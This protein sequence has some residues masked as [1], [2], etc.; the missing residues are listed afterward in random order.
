MVK[1][2]NQSMS[3]TSQGH[4]EWDF[5]KIWMSGGKGRCNFCK[6]V[7]VWLSFGINYQDLSVCV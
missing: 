6:K 1:S 2:R 5:Q 7:A 4:S 3:M